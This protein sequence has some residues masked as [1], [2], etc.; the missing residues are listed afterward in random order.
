M[1]LGIS[2]HVARYRN[3]VCGCEEKVRRLVHFTD[4]WGEIKCSF[5]QET[6]N[7]CVWILTVYSVC[8]R[9]DAV[10]FNLSEGFLL[11]LKQL[12]IKSL[13]A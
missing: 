3:N 12:M 8:H 9:T 2:A 4:F 10:L 13:V 11:K 5:Y 1:W 6:T 7:Q